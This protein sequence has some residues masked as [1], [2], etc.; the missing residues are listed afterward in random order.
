M[1]NKERKRLI[2]QFDGTRAIRRSDAMY[3]T[4]TFLYKSVYNDHDCD[5]VIL[6]GHGW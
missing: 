3:S 5:S 1:R 4:T 2:K 6:E